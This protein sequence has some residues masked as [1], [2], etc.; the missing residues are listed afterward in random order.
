MQPANSR[1]GCRFRHRLAQLGRAAW[2][3]PLVGIAHLGLVTFGLTPESAA[4][5]RQWGEDL[6]GPGAPW[7]SCELPSYLR[8]EP[9]VP[10][11]RRARWR[12]ADPAS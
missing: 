4:S 3:I 10:A 6:R 9:V 5:V 1:C 7:C 8:L 11:G 2:R 12:R